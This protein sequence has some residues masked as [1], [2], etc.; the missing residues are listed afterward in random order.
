M[1]T[2]LLASASPARLAVLRGAGLDPLVTVSGVDEDA[3]LA[4][5]LAAEP[6]ERIRVL[7]EAKA[8]AVAGQ[9][10]AGA[11]P[12][13]DAD[14]DVLVIG[15]D[16]ML[17][18]DG[19]LQGKPESAEQAKQ[20]WRQMAGRGGVLI[21]GHA[22]RRV[23]GGRI[24]ASASA[25]RSTTVRMGRPTEAELEAYITTGEPLA[26]AGALTIDGFGGWFVEG[27]D[28]DP[29]N[30]LGLSLPLTR[31]LLQ[32]VGVRV[33]D[34]WRVPARVGGTAGSPGPDVFAGSAASPVAP[35]SIALA[36]SA[37]PA[38]SPAPAPA[39]APAV[40]VGPTP[41]SR[42]GAHRTVLSTTALDSP[43]RRST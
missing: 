13:V 7:A 27:V 3:V 22:V 16:S 37:A 10:L 15:C 40:A 31:E 33:T 5:L 30:V 18:I 34:L 1:T 26:V 41:A 24:A 38:V 4:G 43:T 23:S 35:V 6:A 21:T 11:V 32:Q 20:R 17:L 29:S 2:V 28:G 14:D 8:D 36:A 19:E 9:V 25:A 39:P 42:N 12:R